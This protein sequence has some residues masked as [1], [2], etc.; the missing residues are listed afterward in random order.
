MDESEDAGEE[1]EGADWP[2]E[3]ATRRHDGMSGTMI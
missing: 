1:R 2:V 3:T